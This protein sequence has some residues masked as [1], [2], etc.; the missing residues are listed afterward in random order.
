MMMEKGSEQTCSHL[1]NE[2]GCSMA[3]HFVLKTVWTA[4]I[5][6]TLHEQRHLTNLR[7]INLHLITI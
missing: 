4:H 3:P 5:Q 7:V 1:K 6:E 2:S